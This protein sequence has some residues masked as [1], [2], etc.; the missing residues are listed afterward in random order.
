MRVC[1]SLNAERNDSRLRQSKDSSANYDSAQDWRHAS[2]ALPSQNNRAK[3]DP[4]VAHRAYRGA[5]EN[6][7]PSFTHSAARNLRVLRIL[8]VE[9]TRDDCQSDLRYP[10]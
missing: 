9:N 5:K 3:S 2:I 4:R 10:F 6:H 8:R 7:E 1:I